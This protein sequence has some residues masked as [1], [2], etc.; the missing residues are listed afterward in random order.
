MSDLGDKSEIVPEVFF[1]DGS[2]RDIYVLDCSLSDWEV[3]AK[4]LE[5]DYELGFDGTWTGGQFPPSIAGLFLTSASNVSTLLKIS[6]G[7][8]I[9]CCHF[10]TVEEIEFRP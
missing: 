6:V 5:S 3:A 10:F 8:V 4:F 1:R 2:L 9:L 7:E